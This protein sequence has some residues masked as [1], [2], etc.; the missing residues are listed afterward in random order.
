VRVVNET[1]YPTA[2]LRRIVALVH[3]RESTRTLFGRLGQWDR[4]VVTVKH[5]ARA[6]DGTGF[7]GWYSGWAHL[8]GTQSHLFVPPERLE[9]TKLAGLWRH[10]LWHLYG[11]EHSEMPVYIHDWSTRGCGY[12]IAAL[13]RR[14]LKERPK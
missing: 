6:R 7:P 2:A 4:L 11:V 5:S 1:R 8:G 10:E 12:V 3:G 13:G 14:L 9:V